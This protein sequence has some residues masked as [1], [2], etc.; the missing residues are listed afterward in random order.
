MWTSDAAISKKVSIKERIKGEFRFETYNA[1]NHPNL[2]PWMTISS[3]NPYS[4]QYN[5]RYNG[6]PRTFE[7][8]LR[9]TF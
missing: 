9:G 3:A 8:S 4:A 2:W 1:M 6:L 5:R 7:I